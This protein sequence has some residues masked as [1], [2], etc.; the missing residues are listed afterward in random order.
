[1]ANE[2]SINARITAD[3]ADFQR[4][5]ADASESLEEMQGVFS[6]VTGRIKDGAKNWGLDLDQFYETGSSIF[7]DFGVDI[8]KFAAHFGV[9]GKVVAAI[10]AA[11]AAL[12]KFGQAMHEARAEIAKGT[13]AVGDDLVKMQDT[14]HATLI[15]GVGRDVTEVAGMIAD[16]NTRFGATGEELVELTGLFDQFSNATGEDTRNSI[17]EIADVMAKWGIET[18]QMAPLLDELTVAS[19]MSGA[20]IG[21]LTGGLKAGQAVFS[22]F[23]MSA[24]DSIALISSLAKNGI[25]SSTAINSLRFA[26]NKFADEGVGAQEGLEKTIEAIQSATTETEALSIASETFGAK[27]GAEMVKVL[28]SGAMAADAFKEAIMNAGGAVSATS[29][30]TRNSA[31]AIDDL[32]SILTGTFAGFGEGFDNFFRDFIDSI[33]EIVKYIAPVIEPIGNIFRDVFSAIGEML[34]VLVANFV[35]FQERFNTAFKAVK[36]I[37]QSAYEVIHKVLGNILEAFKTAFGLIFAILDGKWGLA[38]ANVK[39]LALLAVK[40]ISDILST[41]T[42]LFAKAI[43]GVINLINQVIDKYHSLPRAVQIIDINRIDNVSENTDIASVFGITRKLSETQAEIDSLSGKAAERITGDIGAVKAAAQDTSVAIQ[44]EAMKVAEVT[45]DWDKKL[46]QQQIDILEMRKSEAV[47]TA[48]AE[49]KSEEEIY[50]IKVAYNDKIVEL[51]KKQIEEE[52]KAEIKK[53]KDSKASVAE[54][55]KA[56]SQINEYYDNQIEL[57]QRTERLTISSNK[58][59]EKSEKEAAEN[60][61]HVISGL[62]ESWDA[63]FKNLKERLTEDAGDWTDFF[64]KVES[65]VK[66][67][68]GEALENLGAALVDGADAFEGF[69][70]SAVSALSE[71]LKGLGAQLAALAAVNIATYNYGKAAAAAAGAAAAIAAAG[72]LKAVA[73]NMKKTADAAKSAANSI[74]EFKQKLSDIWSGSSSS[75]SAV[76]GVRQLDTEVRQLNEDIKEQEKTVSDAWNKIPDVL[77]QGGITTSKSKAR[78]FNRLIKEY[79][80]ASQELARLQEALDIANREYVRGL[81]ETSENLKAQITENKELAADYRTLYESVN[82]YNKSMTRSAEITAEYAE[83]VRNELL[84]NTTS[85]LTEAYKDFSSLG[86]DIGE[87]LMDSITE[88]ASKSDFMSSMRD[89]IRQKLMQIAVYTESFSKQLADVGEKLIS[90]IMGG[91]DVDGIASEISDIYETATKKAAKI[92]EVLSGAFGGYITEASEAS[93]A[94]DGIIEE[95][96]IERISDFSKKISALK[97]NIT[98][99]KQTLSDMRT[100]ATASFSA[101]AENYGDISK[102]LSRLVSNAK[103]AY[104][105]ALQQY[106]A[107]ISES[108]DF[109]IARQKVYVQLQEAKKA[110]NSIETSSSWSSPASKMLLRI[111][112]GFL[113]V[114]YNEMGATYEELKQKRTAAYEDYTAAF[115]EYENA[116]TQFNSALFD[117]KEETLSNLKE[118]NENLTT[119]ITLYDSLFAN[120]GKGI[121]TTRI[122]AETI[123]QTLNTQLISVQNDLLNVGTQIGS[124]LVSSISQGATKTDFLGNIKGWLKSQIISLAVYSE[125]FTDKIAGVGQKLISAV[126]GGGGKGSNSAAKSI[127]ALKGELSGLYDSIESSVS[128]IYDIIDEVFPETADTISGSVDNISDSLTSFE[129]AMKSFKESVSDLGGDIAG[130]IVN[131]LT[132]GLSQGDF[133]SSMKDYLRKMLIQSVVYTES[134]KGEIEAIGKTISNAIQ[135]GFTEDTIH[136]VRRDLSWVYEQANKAISSVDTVLG[137]VFS[138]YAD[139]TTSALKGLHI[140]GERG[141]ELVRFRGGERVYN[142]TDTA[143]MMGGGGKNTTMNVTFNNTTDTTAYTMVRQLRQYQR[144]MAI[145]GI[146]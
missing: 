57:I 143:R 23:G 56:I 16:L 39:K 135:G 94:T 13:G 71:V 126:T 107:A 76:S 109:A 63:Y 131:G 140:V 87:K 134:L 124:S 51:K 114:Q 90:A 15:S 127:I 11:T 65:G 145:N 35:E 9:E 82:G 97:G 115:K 123:K 125:A 20:S 52:R 27:N 130:E 70:A 118:E 32:K 121:Q 74:E 93:E 108:S 141:P 50:R 60:T 64:G 80:E 77:K 14:L 2:Y 144:E 53:V 133:L 58:N 113:E 110:L 18:E 84:A 24:T 41:L 44:K 28:S 5:V 136:D 142:A 12:T 95:A 30:A 26:L 59:K 17:N 83:I 68:A 45:F 105:T 128:G 38:W 112:E 100:S 43:N 137:S 88:G 7:K 120:L 37:I 67:I 31:S 21:E 86:K 73:N 19:Q 46:L 10:A 89:M 132:S 55:A 69:G 4:A 48:Q 62:D 22:Q 81:Q 101:L 98:N 85:L 122:V 36:T 6:Q 96:V 42:N 61:K 92:D 99:L 111:E 129:K 78:Y 54:Q 106:S 139:G 103:T 40:N 119:Q 66:E 104:N 3:S 29:D 75:E 116:V 49:G 47:K 72:A 91:G 1:M 138:G 79:K 146:L 8:D 117:L 25:E 34:K 102:T 33:S